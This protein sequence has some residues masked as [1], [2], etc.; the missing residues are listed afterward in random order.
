[1]SDVPLK[2]Y[3]ETKLKLLNEI[4]AERDR[5]YSERFLAQESALKLAQENANRWMAAA[6]EWRQAMNDRE[7]DFLPRNLGYV[8]A[9]LAA[10]SLVLTVVA[11]L[12]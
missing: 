11:K 12:A 5:R 8:F 9:A 3:V 1:M 4:A 7:R 10:L 6:N 2:E